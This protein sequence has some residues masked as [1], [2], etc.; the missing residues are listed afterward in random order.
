MNNLKLPQL[1]NVTPYRIFLSRIIRVAN[2]DCDQY[3]KHNFVSSHSYTFTPLILILKFFFL[4]RTT[5][6]KK[7]PNSFHELG[8]YDLP[9]SIDY[10]ISATG[11]RRLLYVGHSQGTT[12]L[13]V[14]TSMRPEYNDKIALAAGLAPAAFTGYLRGPVAQLTKLT[15]FGVVSIYYIFAFFF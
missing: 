11:Q 2:L 5:R 8:V 15:Y 4:S 14:M 6:K 7:Q 10:V 13:L 3:K 1:I 9:S 12:Q